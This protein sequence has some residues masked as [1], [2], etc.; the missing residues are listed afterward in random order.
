MPVTKSDFKVQVEAYNAKMQNYT[1]GWGTATDE[2]RD[3]VDALNELVTD[4]QTSTDTITPDDQEI[5]DNIEMAGKGVI[6]KINNFEKLELPTPLKYP[7][8]NVQ[9]QAQ[10]SD[11]KAH[12]AEVKAQKSGTVRR[13]SKRR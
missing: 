11:A 10:K 12:K 3:A 6:G 7:E 4:L 5:L 9:P 8:T 13:T 2:L 1:A